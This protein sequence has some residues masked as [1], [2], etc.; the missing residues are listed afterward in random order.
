MLQVCQICDYFFSKHVFLLKKLF[1]MRNIHHRELH[2]LSCDVNVGIFG[3]R[4]PKVSL[5]T[6]E[7]GV[8]VRSSC[9]NLFHFFIRVRHS[10]V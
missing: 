1:K 10:T 2:H 3:Y 9:C 4:K 8:C 6:F 5:E 7:I